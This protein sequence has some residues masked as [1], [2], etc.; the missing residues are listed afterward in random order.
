MTPDLGLLRHSCLVNV[1][2]DPKRVNL[3]FAGRLVPDHPSP[4]AIAA[5]QVGNPVTL[6]QTGGRGLIRDGQG[7]V[8]ST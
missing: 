7:R 4:G 5:A 6:D 1:A 8:R 2:P 3:S